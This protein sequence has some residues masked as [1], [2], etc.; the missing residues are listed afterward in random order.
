MDVV[1]TRFER[2]LTC[3]GGRCTRDALRVI[4]RPLWAA[5]DELRRSEYLGIGIVGRQPLWVRGFAFPVDGQF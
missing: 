2:S 4:P 5:G 3:G 1:R